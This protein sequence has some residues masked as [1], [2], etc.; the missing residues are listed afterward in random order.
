[1]VARSRPLQSTSVP[2]TIDGEEYIA[3]R[4][5]ALE[6]A[7]AA[8]EGQVEGQVEG[9]EEEDG[10]EPDEAHEGD[11]GAAQED[12]GGPWDAVGRLDAARSSDGT[13]VM[14]EEAI[15]ALRGVVPN[16]S[17]LPM[18]SGPW[19]FDPDGADD[20]ALP[21]YLARVGRKAA[22]RAAPRLLPAWLGALAGAGWL[23]GRAESRLVEGA[24]QAR[25]FAA[26]HPFWPRMHGGPTT[27]RGISRQ[28]RGRVV[29][30]TVAVALVVLLL[31]LAA[32]ISLVYQ[33]QQLGLTALPPNPIAANE[34]VTTAQATATATALSATAT[35]IA[36]C[37]ASC[38]PRPT[39]TSSSGGGL[40]VPFVNC[41][42]APTLT[43]TA[44]PNPFAPTATVS[45]A[46]TRQ[47]L[48]PPSTLATCDDCTNDA[49]NGTVA[50]QKISDGA[51]T[52]SGGSWGNN[53]VQTQA[54][55]STVFGV[56]FSCNEA[57]NGVCGASAGAR[58]IDQS[59]NG[60]DCNTTAATS[61]DAGTSNVVGCQVSHVGPVTAAQVNYTNDVAPCGTRCDATWGLY[62]TASVGQN[63]LHAYF[64]PNPCS[65]DGGAAARGTVASALAGGFSGGL[66]A[67][68]IGQQTIYSNGGSCANP[69][70]CAGWSGGQNVGG[71]ST[72]TM[73]ATGSAWELT[74][75][76]SGAQGVQATRAGNMTP[77][78]YAIGGAISTCPSGVTV[79]STDVANVRAT[80]SCPTT[81]TAVYAWSSANLT[82]LK[83]QLAGKTVAQVQ[84]LLASTTGVGGNIAVTVPTG[85]T[86]L[87]QDPNV[88]TLTPN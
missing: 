6:A 80:L 1:V 84:A 40:C 12:W 34:T 19:R 73:C 15:S 63:A 82:A 71:A 61:A 85:Y 48:S 88:I 77:G 5:S 21:D 27:R 36:Y 38:A 18:P 46:A 76:A 75:S 60:N 86:S 28:R 69:A 9:E 41:P 35:A 29:V 57:V 54:G 31:P 49:G 65:G 39:A 55:T 3:V 26:Q 83:Q 64:T 50:G 16:S 74:F 7:M 47:T 20:R 58:V 67:V 30:L 25:A 22:R 2:I 79:L 68:A 37:G 56:L 17:P 72:Y 13:P 45:F 42:P 4:R 32:Y 81:A 59:G 44:A 51:V 43:P 23:W 14:P 33:A 87:P 10:D 52:R 8:V 66:G 24:E 62:D 78:G 11:A 53:W 70:N